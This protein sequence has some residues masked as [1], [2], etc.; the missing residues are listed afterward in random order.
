LEGLIR[1]I[2]TELIEGSKY[3]EPRLREIFDEVRPDVIVQ[4]NVVAFPAVVTAGVPWVRIM[5]CNPL[6]MSDPDLPPTFSGYATTDRTGRGQFRSEYE[7][8]HL[9]PGPDLGA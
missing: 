1:P 5:S 3:V 8:T 2:W 7:S 9:D 4:D 6:E